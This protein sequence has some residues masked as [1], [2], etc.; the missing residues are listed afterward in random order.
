MKTRQFQYDI[1]ISHNRADKEWVR[2]LANRIA[3]EQYNGRALRPWLDE[4]FLDPGELKTNEELTTALDRSK[5]FGLVIS[6]GSLAS[7][8]VNF[9]ID[10]FLET[11]NKHYLMLLIR[12]SSELPE[13][14]LERDHPVI[15]FKEDGKLEQQ[16]KN[17][18]TGIKPQHSLNTDIVEQSIDAAFMDFNNNDP[19][20]FFGEPTVDRDLFYQE[21]SKYP[22]DDLETEGFAV[23]A[24]N[25][26]AMLLE[27]AR[28]EVQ[29]NYKMLLGECLGRSL[30]KNN[31]YRQI[32]QHFLSIT[33]KFPENTSLLFVIVRAYSKLAE[34]DISKVD[35]SILLRTI[36]QLDRLDSISNEQKALEILLGRVG[37]KIRHLPLGELLIKTLSEGGVSSKIVA[38]IAISF[39]YEQSQPVNYITPAK[40]EFSDPDHK[41]ENRKEPAS[42][43]LLSLL[44]DLS[45]DTNDRVSWAV[46]T[47]KIDIRRTSPDVD[48]PYGYFWRNY[49]KGLV[50]TN[51]YN[52]PFIGSVV[53][54]T[55]ENMN[56]MSDNTNVTSVVC[57]TE[58]RI[59]ESLFNQC[60]ALLIL[61]QDPDSLL[62][63]R[64]RNRRIPFGMM[65]EELMSKLNNDD[66]IMVN[67]TGIILWKKLVQAKSA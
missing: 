30:Y 12:N 29:Y 32:S 23:S 48:F 20:G 17:L 8:W 37:G 6:P 47:A 41:N 36:S 39:N 66:H 58:Q 57:L 61:E 33:E 49:S 55:L 65:S 62:C 9:E 67:Q 2:Q 5:I 24:F 15:D 54:I 64:L 1:F 4:Q 27:K 3:A 53:M 63:Q 51:L 38:T 52:A 60:S 10:H 45:T 28:P 16:L 19:G 50:V 40:I 18:W 44:F 46:Q 43:K 11:R 31:A 56:E 13:K 22:V 14:I 34:T 59:V 42:K 35:L 21:L 7:Y 25:R 26:A